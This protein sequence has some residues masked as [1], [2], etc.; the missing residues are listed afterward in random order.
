MY[1]LRLRELLRTVRCLTGKLLHMIN[2]DNN[3]GKINVK[4]SLENIF[5]KPL[6]SVSEADIDTYSHMF[7]GD[8]KTNHDKP[9]MVLPPR[10]ERH[11]WLRFDAHDY[12]D[13]NIHD[14]ETRLGR[15]YDRQIHSGDFLTFVPSY[16]QIKES[17]RRLCHI[18]IA[19]TISD[20]GQAPVKVTTTNIF[21]PRKQGARMSGGHFIAHPEGAL[22]SDYGAEHLDIDYGGDVVTWVA[23]GP[24]RQQ[25]GAAHVD[26][27]D[28]LIDRLSTNQSRFATWMIGRMTQ[29]MDAS[30][31]RYQGFDG[32]FVGSSQVPYQRRSVRQRT[33]GAGTS[34][35]PKLSY[36]PTLDLPTFDPF[37][38]TFL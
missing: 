26:L 23:M 27:E 25:A 17:L 30:G 38:F 28:A 6:D 32:S 36:S 35:A 20:R 19:F 12:L 15:I 5:I 24:K 29:L 2:S 11:L 13:S 22:W 37:G 10:A 21:F 8:L 18:L 16:T 33:D 34:A 9:D 7:D 3:Y 14:Y 1:S 31:L 4:L